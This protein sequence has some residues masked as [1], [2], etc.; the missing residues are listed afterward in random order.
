MYGIL[1]IFTYIYII[2]HKHQAN[3]GKYTIHGSYGRQLVEMLWKPSKFLPCL[4][5]FCWWFHLNILVGKCSPPKNLGEDEPKP[6]KHDTKARIFFVLRSGILQDA[7]YYS[8]KWDSLKCKKLRGRYL[9]HRSEA[10]LKAGGFVIWDRTRNH[11]IPEVGQG[12]AR[13]GAKEVQSCFLQR[14]RPR[15]R[16]AQSPETEDLTNPSFTPKQG[17]ESKTKSNSWYL[18]TDELQ[19]ILI[20]PVKVQRC[21]F[22]L[23]W[24]SRHKRLTFCHSF[25]HTCPFGGRFLQ[26]GEE[27]D[28]R[29]GVGGLVAPCHSKW[30]K[31]RS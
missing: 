19:L 16:A 17:K 13:I 20:V 23:E 11:W 2:Y 6:Q 8:Y 29:F 22:H 10:I 30:Q 14:W 21:S 7:P 12:K 3:V 1:H 27:L 9:F 25:D 5:V 31:Q 4:A 28:C 26:L 24:Y 15:C 18:I